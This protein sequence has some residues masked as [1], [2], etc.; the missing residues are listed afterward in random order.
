MEHISHINMIKSGYHTIVLRK[1]QMSCNNAN[2]LVRISHHKWVHEKEQFFKLWSIPKS[3]LS[4]SPSLCGCESILHD[5]TNT[6]VPIG[7]MPELGYIVQHVYHLRL[8]RR[9]R[10]PIISVKQEIEKA[11]NVIAVNYV[12]LSG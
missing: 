5:A 10:C 6:S 9:I 4:G 1:T 3:Y 11:H 12:V 8:F 2:D 7:T